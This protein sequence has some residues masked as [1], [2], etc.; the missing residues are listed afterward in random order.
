MTIA[1]AARRFS[2]FMVDVGVLVVLT[3]PLIPLTGGIVLEDVIERGLPRDFLLAANIVTA[4]YY[5][6]LTGWRGQTLGKLLVRTKVVGE[7]S[8]ETPT[9]WQAVV[10]WVVP[11]VA[12]S[13]PGLLSLA[14]VIVYGWLLADD[15]NQGIHDKAARTLVIQVGE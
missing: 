9:M 14:G 10:R 3:I 4:A 12:S 15:R 13:L 11:F 6:V 8:S 5:I 2:G 1:P 7:E